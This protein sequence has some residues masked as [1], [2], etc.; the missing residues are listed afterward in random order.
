MEHK[1]VTMESY[2]QILEAREHRYNFVLYLIEQYKKPVLCAKINYPGS[3]KNTKEYEYAFNLLKNIIRKNFQL[4]EKME[5]TAENTTENKTENMAE[6]K[7]ENMTGNKTANTKML[8]FTL[9]GADGSSFIISLSKDP[10]QEKQKAIE[11][12]M[13]HELGRI[14]DIDIYDLSG[15]PIDRKSMGLHLRKCIIC[16][17]NTSECMKNN[18]HSLE[19]VK[20]EINKLINNFSYK[21]NELP[22]KIGEAA[23]LSMLYEIST[24]PSP[25][26][27]SPHSNG[28][29]NDMDYFTFLKS[30]ASLSSSMIEFV[31]VGINEDD[32]HLYKLRKIGIE[33]EARMFEV[34]EGVNT[35]KGLLFLLGVVCCAA[36]IC[37][38]K[39]LKINRDNISKSVIE[40]CKGIVAKELDEYLKLKKTDLKEDLLNLSN[41][42]K[43]FSNHGI[44][45]IRGEV[46]AGLPTVLNTGL[47]YF[48]EALKSGLNIGESLAHSLIGIMSVIDDT[49]VINRCG[50][51]GL[52]Y[53]QE[54]SR[55][56]IDLG[57]ILAAEGR[58]HIFEMDKDF[59]NKNISPG[60]AA[61]L[62]AITAFIFE[63][64]KL[65][66]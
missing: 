60:G 30:T 33:A 3:N 10:K 47:P 17:K 46:E 45:G 44:K 38:Q 41:G 54:Q 51:D 24:F 1:G 61:D 53:M 27:V 15:G 20:N 55:K 19:L 9:E 40:I 62:L 13:K 66:V 37:I 2:D 58:K 5:N 59:I 26:L 34:T 56:A 7:T 36:G 29:H 48:E 63:L 28:A 49:T 43:L 42:I 21:R 23:I 4:E 14:F 22:K 18:S 64:E 31:S 52:T 50:F 8:A 35:Q 6:Y 39:N 11:I 25:G 12:E 16:D 32:E 57:G 65:E